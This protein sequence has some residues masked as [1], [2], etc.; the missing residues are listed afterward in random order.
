ME[1]NLKTQEE[2]QKKAQEIFSYLPTEGLS[3]ERRYCFA[4]DMFNYHSGIAYYTASLV[5]EYFKQTDAKEFE[6]LCNGEASVLFYDG[7]REDLGLD[8]DVIV[9]TFHKISLNEKVGNYLVNYSVKYYAKDN[10]I[11]NDLSLQNCL[12]DIMRAALLNNNP[13]YVIKEKINDSGIRCLSVS[14]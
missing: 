13:N 1:N 5:S 8:D 6:V 12:Y 2:K 9:E 11:G 3:E 10:C 7:H 4:V 14:L